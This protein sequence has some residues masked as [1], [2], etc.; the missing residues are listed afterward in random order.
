MA[1]HLVRPT[2]GVSFG[3]KHTISDAEA[4]VGQVVIDFQVDYTLAASVMMTSSAGVGI[5]PADYTITYPAAGQIQIDGN[6]EFPKG[7]LVHII[8]NRDYNSD[9]PY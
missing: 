8:A 9:N 4:E 5:S 7:A 1:T 6:S 3:Y 2:N